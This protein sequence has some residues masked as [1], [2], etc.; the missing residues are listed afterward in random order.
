MVFTEVAKWME[1][2]IYYLGGVRHF[3]ALSGEQVIIALKSF[4]ESTE[5]WAAISSMLVAF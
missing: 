1:T 2:D 3:V 4:V 5:F